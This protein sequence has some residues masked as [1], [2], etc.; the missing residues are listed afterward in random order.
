M[1][2]AETINDVLKQLDAIIEDCIVNNSRLGFFAYIY[3]RTTAEIAKEINLGNFEDNK[4]METFDIEF[5]N[6]YLT[7]YQNYNQGLSSSKSW[8][9]AFDSAEDQL[10]IIQHI[11]FG[12]NAHINLDL[13]IAT[14]TTMSGKEIEDIESDF[15][16]VNDILQQITN[17]LQDRLSTVSPL[18]FLID[19]L[20]KNTDEKIINFS[21]RKARSQAWRSANF[22]WSL[23]EENSEKSIQKIDDFVYKLSQII[24]NPNSLLLKILL[25]I[26]QFFETKKIGKIIYRLRT[27]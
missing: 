14:A 2:K 5:A 27:N 1:E 12:M 3:R 20:G 24:K 7:A 4:R 15:N 6:L 19:T 18:L 9:F 23:G 10:T 8:A 16:K 11:L 21:M 13:S 17:E 26:I 22:L 25:K